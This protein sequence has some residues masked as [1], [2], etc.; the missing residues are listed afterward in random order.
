MENLAHNFDI[1]LQFL[2]LF[3]EKSG[4]LGIFVFMFLESTF[5]PL[6]SELIMIPVGISAASATGLNLYW[7]ILAGAFGNLC[8]AICK[9]H[10]HGSEHHAGT[11]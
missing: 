5:V 9:D 10:C 6:P 4:Y 1:I 8:G 2:V 3:A 11:R 7:S